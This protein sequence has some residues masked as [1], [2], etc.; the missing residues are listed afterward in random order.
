MPIEMQCLAVSA[1]ARRKT[2][3]P[4]TFACLGG[5]RALCKVKLRLG[6]PGQE[7][8]F[9]SCLSQTYCAHQVRFGADGYLC[10]CAVRKEI[11]REYRL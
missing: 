2:D 5:K 3:C 9:V 7:V 4:K 8:L 10:G 6:G 1:E 11:Y